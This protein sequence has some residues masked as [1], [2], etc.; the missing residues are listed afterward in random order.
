MLLTLGSWVTFYVKNRWHQRPEG[1]MA[2]ERIRLKSSRNCSNVEDGARDIIACW[3]QIQCDEKSERDA[4]VV[5]D[6]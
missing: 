1:V 5:T 4:N 3:E 6:M 2:R